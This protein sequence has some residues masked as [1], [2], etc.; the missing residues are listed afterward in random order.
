MYDFVDVREPLLSLQDIT[1]YPMFTTGLTFA[2]KATASGQRWGQVMLYT[3]DAYPHHAVAPVSFLW[4]PEKQSSENNSSLGPDGAR[5]DGNAGEKES[6]LWMWCHPAAYSA[7]WTQLSQACVLTSPPTPTPAQTPQ[8]SE[9]Q[10]SQ[11]SSEVQ[12]ANASKVVQAASATELAFGQLRLRS[13][14]DQF[15]KLRLTGPASNLVLS[16]TLKIANVDS[17]S[18]RPNSEDDGGDT[19][20]SKFWWQDYYADEEHNSQF[21]TQEKVWQVL[22]KCQTPDEVPPRAAV[23]LTV[24]DPRVLL[25]A[26]RTKVAREETGKIGEHKY[27]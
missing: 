4:Q 20:T 12:S 5:M 15:V 11:V 7:V 21:T 10:D 14:K 26:V 27:D 23:A 3:C 8:R 24:R 2:A 13:L 22:T 18:Q 19:M 25:P 6:R 17:H 1:Q 16:E 9:S